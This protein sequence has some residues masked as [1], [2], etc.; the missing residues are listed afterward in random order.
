MN[1]KPPLGIVGGGIA[2]LAAAIA[3][4]QRGRE[5]VV[6]ES[7]TIG[8]DKV[9]GEFLS[10]E[11]EED[12]DALGCGDL[13]SALKP[14]PLRSVALFGASGAR[15][16]L[17]L[18]GRPA[19]GLTRAALEAFLARRARD[20]G[21]TV[22][23][24][25]PVRAMVPKPPRALEIQSQAGA[26]AV[27]GLV[28]AM[29]KRSPL[30][31]PLALPRAHADRPTFVALKAYCA[32]TPLEADVELYLVPGGYIGVNPVEDGRIGICALL[33]G[34]ARPGWQTLEA[35]GTR[36][37]ALAQR[38]AALGPPTQKPRGLARFGFGAQA[39][40][41]ACPTTGVPL[42]FAGDAARLVPS[43]T[44]DGMAIALHSGRLAA[45]ATFSPDPIRAYTRAFSRAFAARFLVAS[46][47][48][49]LLLRPSVFEFLAP[50]VGRTPRLVDMLYRATRG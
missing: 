38:L 47:L 49:G 6:W 37:P 9:C 22:L 23:E 50:L 8:R 2:G 14:A 45:L 21:A 36:H 4:A 10:P 30:D 12:L 43:F 41:R 11:A 20:A 26:H 19:L 16:D 35:Y 46:T 31:A 15:L 28:L 33:D 40:A 25:T 24:R 1:E 7:G 29:G 17:T 34:D 32:P 13:A 5:V 48:H 27:R 39:I 18:P 3:A 44:G 42:L